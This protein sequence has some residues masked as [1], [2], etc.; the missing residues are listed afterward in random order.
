MIKA[1][2]KRNVN[3]AL[4]GLVGD[5]AIN[6]NAEWRTISPR[7]METIEYKGTWITEYQSPCERVLFLPERNANPFFHFFESLWIMAGGFD[8]AY[9][10]Q[11]NSKISEFSDDGKVF[12]APYGQRLRRHFA[13]RTENSDTKY[14]IWAP[15]DQ[16]VETIALLKAD[17][18]TRRAV[19]MI[20]NPSMDCN[21][22][23]KDIPCNDILMFKLR[24]GKL[25]LTVS[26]R[27]NDAIWGAYGANVVQFS[28]ILEFMA[29]AISAQVGVYKQISDSM[30][31]YRS[32][33]TWPK[34]VR[35]C[36][37]SA[38]HDPYQEG[39]VKPHALLA[40]GEDWQAWLLDCEY[41]VRGR[42]RN[43]TPCKLFTAV[44]VPMLQ[45]WGLHKKGDTVGAIDALNDCDA[46]DWRK[47]C[48]E[49]LE[50]R[51]NNG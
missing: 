21:I 6:G 44:A 24:D 11:F 10:S 48:K 22:S 42:S 37:G 50:R 8:V 9:L 43:V 20:W 13:R 30:H 27:S 33:P 31:I 34:I 35:A 12:H 38:L 19:M 46:S 14:H 3:H 15:V 51:L 32:N 40:P 26:C 2:I 4:H 29:S 45:A 36:Y 49:W 1:F 25:D 5:I 16:I 17:P 39:Y 23:S 7:G 41:F 47:A 18:D 28:V